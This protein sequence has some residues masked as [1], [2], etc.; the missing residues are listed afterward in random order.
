MYRSFFKRIFDIIFSCLAIVLLL[1]AFILIAT[2]NLIINGSPIF[3]IQCRPGLQGKIFKIYKFRTMKDEHDKNGNLLSDVHRIT[4]FGNFLRSTSLDELPGLWNVLNGNM[5][6][7]GPRPLLVEYV[8]LYSEEQ[9]KRHKVRPGVTG[10]AQVNGRNTISW[11]QKFKM[12]VWYVEN[13]S[14]FLD[15]KILLMTIKKVLT[16]DGISHNNHVTMKKFTGS[17]YK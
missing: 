13:Q 9:A 12:D 2:I 4:K 16:R 11:E 7:V 1:P 17:S 14:F 10:W 8:P 3:F 5:S 6:F 15:I